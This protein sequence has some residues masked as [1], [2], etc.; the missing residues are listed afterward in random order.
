MTK[1]KFICGVFSACLLLLVQSVGPALGQ[2]ELMETNELS[3]RV[4][5]LYQAGKY[6]EAIPL[7]RRAL[8]IREQALGPAHP[9]VALSLT[10]LAVLL[11]A[12]GDYAGARPLYERALRIREPAWGS[13]HPPV[14]RSLNNLAE[15][16]RRNGGLC[17][18]AAAV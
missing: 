3:Q 10:D 11:E 14:A 16:F 12:T 4:M 9:A 1:T 6:A 2:Q 8:G 17:G 18:G 7:A 5:K 15:L 13:M